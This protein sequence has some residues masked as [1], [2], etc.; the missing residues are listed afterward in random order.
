MADREG[1][2][3]TIVEPELEPWSVDAAEAGILYDIL[4]REVVPSFYERGA[5]NVPGAGCGW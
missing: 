4:E 2:G 3:W 1:R 5:D